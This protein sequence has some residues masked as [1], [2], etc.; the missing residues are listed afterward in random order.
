MEPDGSQLS[1]KYYLWAGLLSEIALASLTL[2]F[3]F[4]DAP[5]SN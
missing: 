1:H 4:A 3:Y 2:C 5:I